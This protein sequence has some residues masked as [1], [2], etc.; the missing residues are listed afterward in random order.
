MW[1][2]E[3]QPVKTRITIQRLHCYFAGEGKTE[4]SS[5]K[6]S[7]NGKHGTMLFSLERAEM[8]ITQS[9]IPLRIHRVQSYFLQS[10]ENQKPSVKNIVHRVQ[11]YFPKK[12]KTENN[13]V[14]NSVNL[15]SGTIVP[16]SR[17]GKTQNRSVKNGIN[18][19]EGGTL[20]S[21]EG[22]SRATEQS[23]GASYTL[24]LY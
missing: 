9:I 1:K 2:T 8:K 7:I 3:N 14:K 5:A 4:N 22:A 20:F 10:G 12:S 11:C 16:F 17:K 6:N 24:K 13:S 21:Q 15:T 23:K 18:D 19:T